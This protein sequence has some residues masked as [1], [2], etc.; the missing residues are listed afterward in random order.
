LEVSHRLLLS[1]WRAFS[2][3]TL[4]NV[5]FPRT[6]K[7]SS[8]HKHG[9]DD[10]RSFQGAHCAVGARDICAGG[11]S[12]ESPTLFEAELCGDVC[13]GVVFTVLAV[14]VLEG[15]II[16]QLLLA[17]KASPWTAGWQ[18]VEWPF[19]AHTGGAYWRA[20]DGLVGLQGESDI[21]SANECTQGQ[22]RS[23]R[24]RNPLSRPF[25]LRAPHDH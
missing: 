19:C 11:A 10:G 1:T 16:S 23:Q 6:S 2:I 4:L 7:P 5:A 25:Q 20:N 24:R 13:P 3:R 22:H 17:V 21:L 12:T 9:Y 18:L 8:I 15:L 14:G